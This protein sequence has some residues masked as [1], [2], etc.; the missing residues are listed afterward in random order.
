[1]NQIQ[2]LIVDD[3]PAVREG[4]RA[5][6]DKFD[7]IR[8]IGV[9]DSGERALDFCR[10][11][12]LDVAL[13]DLYMPGMDGIE[14]IKRLKTEFPHI[15]IVMLTHSDRDDNIINAIDAGAIGYLVKDA[16]IIEIAHAIRAAASGK[17]TLSPDALEALIRAHTS[18][19]VHPDSHLT[20][21]EYEVIRL[22]VQGLKNPQI[23]EE[24]FI[25]LSTVKFHISMIFK[26]LNVATR[27]EAVVKV[28]ELGLL[29]SSGS[30]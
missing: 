12:P 20:E 1:M 17:R 7:E 27:T 15:S 26:K 22:M 29:D 2:A 10:R 23:A 19:R 5:V 4:L 8:V 16:E 14:T 30:R 9:A 6:L 18:P 21:R 13:V 3:H 24:L 11:N 28:M 25:T